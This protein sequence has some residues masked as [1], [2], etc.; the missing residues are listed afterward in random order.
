MTTIGLDI[1]G[2]NLKAASATGETLSC[3]FPLWKQPEQLAT[4]LRKLLHELPPATRLAV[5]MTGELA[6]CFTLKSEGVARILQ[7][8]TAAAPGI[9]TRVWTTGGRFVA[10]RQIEEWSAIA[11]AN[12]HAL[13]TWVGQTFGV[14]QGILLDIGSTTTDVIPIVA[15]RPQTTGLTDVGRLLA[16]ELIYAGVRR[17]PLCALVRSVPF[18][19]QSCP[20]AAEVFSTTRDLFL[21]LGEEPEDPLD[22]ET[23]NGGP[24]TITAAHDRIARQLCCDRSECSFE[25]AVTIATYVR[26]TFVQTVQHSLLAHVERWNLTGGDIWLSGSGESFAAKSLWDYPQLSGQRRYRLSERW[27]AEMSE[28]AC[29]YAVARLG[30]LETSHP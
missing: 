20:V 29:A 3:A 19:G 11:A 25:E 24:A 6:D 23:A 9:E 1:G 10:A 21:L 4:A 8:V 30:E 22:H 2:A 15:R 5:T 18:R 7:S 26:T 14:E 12:W 28:C 13:A 27:S 17:T 16:G